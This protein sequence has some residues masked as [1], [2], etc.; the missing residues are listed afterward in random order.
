MKNVS[1]VDEAFAAAEE[2]QRLHE[3]QRLR[4][5][6]NLSEYEFEE[7]KRIREDQVWDLH[8][9]NQV[10]DDRV[11]GEYNTR[12]STFT[13]FILSKIPTYMSGPSAGGKTVLMDACIDCL[14]PGDGVLIEGGS[15][16]VIFEMQRDIKKAKYVVI[17]ELNKV[18]P[19]VIEIFKSWGEGKT[20]EY[21]RANVQGG[22]KPFT[23]ECRPFIFSRADESAD[24]V[25]IGAEFR[26]RLIELTVDGSQDQTKSIMSRQAEDVENPFDIKQVDHMRKACLRWHI[27]NLPEYDVYVNPAAGI[28]REYIPT[29]FTTARRD[30][31]KYIK[32]T[33]GIAR[34]YHKDRMTVEINGMKTMF[35]TPQDMFLNH[36]IFGNSL[37]QSA[38]RCSP[39]EKGMLRVISD[40]GD[41]TKQHLQRFLRQEGVNSTLKNIEYHLK[42]LVDIGY[43]NVEKPGRENIYSISELYK[44][45]VEI[46]PNFK[47]VIDYAKDTMRSIEHYQPYADEYIERF[48][49][50][51]NLVV[52][53][54]ITGE[55]INILDYDFGSPNDVGVS[56]ES[57]RLQKPPAGQLKL[58]EVKT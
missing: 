44:E 1:E 45:I 37:V 15:D 20:F 25:D 58:S 21:K 24:L 51:E 23:L 9:V 32:N 22:Y 55:L 42:H 56:S 36:F 11:V 49:T 39:L 7:F 27:S 28:L 38:L 5:A 31:P 43:V 54:P 50:P 35:V 29:V 2:A 26:S 8:D 46:N 16:K 53:N 10:L 6:L 34:F 12:M 48:C 40:Q 57:T 4:E 17:S 14:M 18:N 3:E 13:I 33:E 19:M 30:F 52:K 41:S 47:D